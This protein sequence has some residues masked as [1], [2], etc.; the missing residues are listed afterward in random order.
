[1]DDLTPTPTTKPPSF[2]EIARAAGEAAARASLAASQA[3][4]AAAL[5]SA[6]ANASKPGG[7]TSEFKVALG[8]VVLT[9][10]T[11]ALSVGVHALPFL[12]LG[13]FALPAVAAGTG[14][15]AG[16]Y[17]LARGN[18]KSAALTAG[19]TAL[20]TLAAPTEAAESRLRN[21]AGGGTLDAGRK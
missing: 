8:G 13:P 18:V 11:A 1:M 3:A 2:A 6:M 7:H 14:L 12:P 21:S 20:E 16:L 4:A 9:G 10:I 5:S 19:K 17:A 15:L